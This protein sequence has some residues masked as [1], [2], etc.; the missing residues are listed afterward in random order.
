MI[1]AH[2][3]VGFGKT[4]ASLNRIEKSLRDYVDQ[5]S[6]SGRRAREGQQTLPPELLETASLGLHARPSWPRKYVHVH[7]V[8]PS[9]PQ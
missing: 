5:P 2:F 7:R 3:I 1:A 6:R 8:R 9:L 4:R